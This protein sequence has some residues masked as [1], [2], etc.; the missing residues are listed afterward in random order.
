MPINEFVLYR[1]KHNYPVKQILIVCDKKKD[2]NVHIP[3]SIKAFYVGSNLSNIRDIVTNIEKECVK[4]GVDV[5][6]HAHHQKAYLQFILAT[7]FLGIREKS[8]YTV[9]SSFARRNLKYRISSIICTLWANYAN[10]VSESAYCSYDTIVK[11]IKGEHFIVIRNGVDIFRID[12]ALKDLT[13]IRDRNI[14]VTVGRIIPIKNQA[15]LISL[16]KKLPEKKLV[17]IGSEDKNQ[18]LKSLAKEYNVSDRVE[19]TG[20]ISRDRLFQKLSTAGIYV[21]SSLVEG[22]PVSVLEAM[23]VGLIPIL[24]DIEPHIEIAAV[25]SDVNVLSLNEDKWV[26]KISEYD[27]LSEDEWKCL[28]SRLVQDAKINFSLDHMHEE[29]FKIYKRCM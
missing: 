4:E 23:R 8:I 14:L 27:K 25:S 29:Y 28:Q 26:N 18:S 20:L 16:L 12:E 21:S 6:Y 2:K 15:F 13:L 1:E 9:H 17:I 11:K 10:C 7:L 22:L 5:V 24:S 19:F 3:K